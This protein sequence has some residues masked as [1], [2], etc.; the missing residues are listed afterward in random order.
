MTVN[1]RRLRLIEWLEIIQKDLQ[2]LLHNQHIFRELQKI[3]EKNPRFAES[4]GLFTQWMA[5]NFAQATAVGIRRFAKYN[6]KDKDS[7]SLLRFL[8]EVKK[9]PDL[10]TRQ[11]HLALYQ[12]KGA[13]PHMGHS[14]F[15]EV[16]GEG[17]DRL[18]TSL[19]DGQIDD[20]KKSVHDVEKYADRR[21]AHY[22]RRDPKI[23]TFGDL[24]DAMASMETIV[25]LY[26]LLLTGQS[27]SQ[28]LPTIQGEWMSIFQ[29]PWVAP[30]DFD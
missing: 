13:Y 7:V 28:L 16:A 17:N 12:G 29:F 27:M 25:I 20:L 10:I 3:A 4:S 15:D 6:E 2:V 26:R 30:D 1:E 23:P 19:I 18:P 14:V 5:W 8:N 24:S 21:V 9:H 22:D 11:T